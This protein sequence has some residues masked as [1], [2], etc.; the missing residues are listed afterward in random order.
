MSGN[1]DCIGECYMCVHGKPYYP[2][3]EQNINQKNYRLSVCNIG[4]QGEHTFA[5]VRN[6]GCK[7][8]ENKEK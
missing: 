7:Y 6:R 2:I 5:A 3:Q 4:K 1:L 8:F